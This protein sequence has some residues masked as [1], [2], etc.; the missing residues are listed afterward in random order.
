MPFLGGL[1][2]NALGTS[3]GFFRLETTELDDNVPRGTLLKIL[4]WDLEPH[5]ET[6]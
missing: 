3:N 6:K 2:S 5:P 4:A 1:G